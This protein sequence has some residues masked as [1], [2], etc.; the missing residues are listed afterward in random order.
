MQLA[1]TLH[2]DSRCEAVT[3]IAVDVVR[4][5]AGCLVLRYLATGH[6][7][8]VRLPGRTLPS[9]TDNLWQHTCFE[10]FLREPSGTAYCELNFAPSTQW[11]AYGFSAYREGM[12]AIEKIGTPAFDIQSGETHLALQAELDLS[13]VDVLAANPRWSL[14][15]SAVI[16]ETSGRKSYWALAHPPGKPDFHHGQSFACELRPPEQT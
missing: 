11:A 8:D 14:G 12:A 7:R 3:A 2:P 6:I 4:P 9:R 5:R 15:L 16:E 10:A 13:A 1:L